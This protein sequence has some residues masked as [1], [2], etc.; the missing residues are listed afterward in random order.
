MKLLVAV[1]FLIFSTSVLAATLNEV[2]QSGQGKLTP[3]QISV[4]KNDLETMSQ[5]KGQHS[6]KLNDKVFGTNGVLDGN[7]YLE[8]FLSRVS[9]LAYST[10]GSGGSTLAAFDDGIMYV[11]DNYFA[12][13]PLIRVSLLL[14][15]AG[16][17]TTTV[18]AACPI[19]FLDK[20]G[21]DIRSEIT[22][23]K[24]EGRLVCADNFNDSYVVQLIFLKNIVN[25]C[26]NCEASYKADARHDAESVFN[27]VIDYYTREQLKSDE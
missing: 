17:A 5:I 15:E 10:T 22:G 26:D 4:V 27:R 18:H 20:N 24:F 1:F 19:P 2:L 23:A 13:T 3:Q 6:S 21:N 7:K 25:N 8:Y 16:H 12:S 11:T 14:H 9:S